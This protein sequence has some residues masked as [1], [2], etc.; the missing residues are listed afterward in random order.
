LKF[1]SYK[2]EGSQGGHS[3]YCKIAATAGTQSSFDLILKVQPKTH[4]DTKQMN[5]QH[6]HLTLQCQDYKVSKRSL[7]QRSHFKTLS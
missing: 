4:N 1:I 7:D 5:K 2:P 6:K 3:L